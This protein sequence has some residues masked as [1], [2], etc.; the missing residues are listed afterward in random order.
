MYQL[1]PQQNVLSLSQSHIL[2]LVSAVR[3]PTEKMP[4]I[5][6]CINLFVM[7]KTAECLKSLQPLPYKS[8][9]SA[10]FLDLLS[11]RQPCKRALVND[12][13]SAVL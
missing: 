2:K 10:L 5:T 3:V 13:L 6:D 7:W 8:Y 4:G 12:S 11:L 9:H 1:L